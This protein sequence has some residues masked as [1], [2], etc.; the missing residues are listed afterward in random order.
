[1]THC[2]W[3]SLIE[4]IV[5]GVPMITWPLCVE[6]LKVGLSPKFR[7]DDGIVEKEEIAI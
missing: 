6:G 7:E 4:S 5:A 2:G 1:M 3:K